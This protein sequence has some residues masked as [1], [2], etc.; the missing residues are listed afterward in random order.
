MM[1]VLL[2]R[3]HPFRVYLKGALSTTLRTQLDS[4]RI[5]TGPRLQ[6]KG[7][8][9]LAAI[10]LFLMVVVVRDGVNLSGINL[11]DSALGLF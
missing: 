3:E 8:W 1:V 9:K 7:R 11:L 6:H 10:V 2:R 5:S 4:L